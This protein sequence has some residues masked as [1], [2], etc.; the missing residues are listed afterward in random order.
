MPI[1]ISP[2]N[3]RTSVRASTIEDASKILSAEAEP[4]Y[5]YDGNVI[6]FIDSDSR[7][8]DRNVNI[9]LMEYIARRMS[10]TVD[11]LHLIRGDGII[12]VKTII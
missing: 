8:S 1:L 2:A 12:I 9:P 11:S 6:A 5:D 4:F 7:Y 10:R 3:V